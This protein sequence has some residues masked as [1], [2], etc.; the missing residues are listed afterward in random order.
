[1][2]EIL[3]AI[4][5]TPSN[6]PNENYLRGLALVAALN[7]KKSANSRMIQQLQEKIRNDDLQHQAAMERASTAAQHYQDESE[8]QGLRVQQQNEAL[9]FKEG[10]TQE[11]LQAGKSLL[12]QVNA[13]DKPK[14]SQEWRDSVSDALLDNPDAA[15]T[16]EYKQFQDVLKR[17]K[18]PTFRSQQITLDQRI[19]GLGIN[20]GSVYKALENPELVENAPDMPGRVK[21][22][23][24]HQQIQVN[25]GKGN[26]VNTMVPVYVPVKQDTWKRLQD[27]YKQIY[28]S[29]DTGITP[30]TKIPSDTQVD[31][32]PMDVN[33]RQKGT[34]YS[35]PKGNLTWTGTGW[36]QPPQN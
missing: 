31:P 12:Q 28:P 34:T 5:P 8:I 2:P 22:Y 24:G 4:V 17:E 11:Q 14:H 13:I 23:A 30:I 1:M 33:L 9:H 10:R 35:T 20:K 3:P 36:Q 27:T 32:A 15:G 18:N 19:Q 26:M 7:E 6:V 29:S 25:D 16:P 21:V